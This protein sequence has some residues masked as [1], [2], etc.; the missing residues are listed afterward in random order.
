MKKQHIVYLLMIFLAQFALSAAYA[1]EQQ[2]EFQ[3]PDNVE[4]HQ[5]TIWSEGSRLDGD[6]YLPKDLGLKE[7][8]PAIV[9]SHG[10]G[11]TKQKIQ[12]E[13]A[14]FCSDG[15][16]TLAFT[17][18]GWGGSEGKMVLL[19]GMPKLDKN[20]EA[21]VK[22]LFIRE[23]VDPMD[24]IQDYRAAVDYI[25]G[26]PNVDTTRIGAWGTSYGG[27]IVLWSVA[28]DDRIVAAVSQVGAMVTPAGGMLRMIKQRALL[29]AREGLVPLFKDEIPKLKGHPNFPKMI[30]HDTVSVAH[31]IKIPTLLIDAEHEQI[32]NRHDAGERVFDIIRSKGSTPVR[33]EVIPGIKHWEIYSKGYQRATDLAL[34]WFDEYL[35]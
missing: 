25:M 24:W 6:L 12:R 5:V 7:K 35:R 1:T 3:L 19:N 22:V 20:N 13:A 28:H 27:A 34:E 10:W 4:V 30:Q 11:G 21:T 2:D 17:Y 31:K 29:A 18:R 15:F 23:L 32:F 8:R 9:M 26:E 14:K 16:I 33:Y